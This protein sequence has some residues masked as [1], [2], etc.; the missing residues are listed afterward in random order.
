MSGDTPLIRCVAEAI[1]EASFG[2]IPEQEL[3]ELAKTAIVAWGIDGSHQAIERALASAATV[4]L[5]ISES[6]AMARAAIIAIDGHHSERMERL[7]EAI[8]AMN[9]YGKDP[10]TALKLYDVLW[11]AICHQTNRAARF[12]QGDTPEA[13][14]YQALGHAFFVYGRSQ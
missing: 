12:Y 13:R 2:S 9:P 1:D 7:A 8:S 4:Q 10:D 11:S 3:R 5:H 14:L 6:S